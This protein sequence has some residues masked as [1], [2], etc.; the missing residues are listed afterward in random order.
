MDKFIS[1]AIGLALI[2]VAMFAFTMTAKL[3]GMF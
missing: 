3:W 1:F 2:S